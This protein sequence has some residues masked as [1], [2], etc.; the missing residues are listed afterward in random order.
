MSHAIL[1]IA[2]SKPPAQPEDRVGK[3]KRQGNIAGHRRDIFRLES[4][5]VIQSDGGASGQDFS[6]PFPDIAAFRAE[7]RAD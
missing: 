7:I 6:L 2:V 5:A 3:E 4:S 1:A